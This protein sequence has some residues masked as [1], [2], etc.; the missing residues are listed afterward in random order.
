MCRYGRWRH[1]PIDDLLRLGGGFALQ[2]GRLMSAQRRVSVLGGVPAPPDERCLLLWGAIVKTS[3]RSISVVSFRSPERP[4]LNYGP[5][6]GISPA[7]LFFE[8]ILAFR[9]PRMASFGTLCSEGR[10]GANT[11]SR[12]NP[13]DRRSGMRSV[14]A[15]WRPSRRG[16]RT[17]PSFSAGSSFTIPCPMS[18][19]KTAEMRWRMRL[20]VSIDPRASISRRT[21]STRGG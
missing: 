14:I 1:A 5:A 8:A 4:S 21:L 12:L 2:P 3:T 11:Q 20:A 15:G 6:V 9:P 18:K 7:G 16:L 17:A 10:T 13:P 19:V